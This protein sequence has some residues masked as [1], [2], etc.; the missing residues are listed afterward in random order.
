VVQVV[1]KLVDLG[2]A[3]T[4]GDGQLRVRRGASPDKLAE[5]IRASEETRKDLERSRIDMMRNYA[6]TRGCRA[7]FVLTYFGEQYEGVCGTCDNCESGRSELFTEAANASPFP[8]GVRV[9][10]DEFGAGQVIRTDGDALVVLF[11]EG[12]YRTLSVELVVERELLAL[13]D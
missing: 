10:H 2:A 13:D 1:N 6:E 11:D 3:T 4:G 12:G 8:A 5:Q 9:S 7:R